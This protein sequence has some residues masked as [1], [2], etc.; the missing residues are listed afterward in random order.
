MWRILVL[1]ALD[2]ALMATLLAACVFVATRRLK[3]PAVQHALWVLV[4]LK[5]ISPPLLPAPW[6]LNWMRSTE[7]PASSERPLPRASDEL[8]LLAETAFMDA[9]AISSGNLQ[10]AP[11]PLSN[12]AAESGEAAAIKWPPWEIIV[13]IAWQSGTIVWL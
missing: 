3:N 12:D 1:A 4:L 13:A 9:S 11:P 10:S 5:L 8:A 6:G 2:N 7:A